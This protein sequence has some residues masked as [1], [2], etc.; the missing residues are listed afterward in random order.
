MEE[1]AA[2][3]NGGLLYHEVQEGKLCAV[4]CVNTTLQGPF[5][6]EFDLSALA[7]DL[8]QRERQVMSEGA[9]G[10]ATTAA[11][12]FLAEG[13][14]SHN[15]S[16]GGDFSIQV[17]QKALEV[18]DLQVIP[19][20]SPD[21]GSCL[22]D[23]ELETA[24]ICHLQDHWF[25]I[26]KVNGEWYNFNSLYPAPEHLSKFYLSAFIDTLK[27]SGWSIFAVRGNFPKECPMATEGS[28]GFG[29]WLTPDDAR[30]ITSSCNQVQTPTQ[31]AGVS[32]V[33]DQ[34][35]EMSEMDMIAA[36]QE[37]ADLNAAIAASLMDTGGPFANYAAHEESRS[38]DAFAIES[39]SGEMSKDGNLEEQGANKSETS[40]PNSDNIES[41]SGSNPKQN[42]TSL[43]GKESIKED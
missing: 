30:R 15:V 37:E 31:Q 39:T 19:L 14:G 8:D 18:W 41:A 1:A 23:P 38:Q 12:D 9:A 24:F 2:A 33:A 21:V 20:D 34:S 25:C 32:L 10:A 35:E 26:R 40:E 3:S 29:Q 7:V 27:G 13:E 11:G 42:T 5:F 17:L 6:S 16:L 4:H 28:N 22:F 36:Q 43:E